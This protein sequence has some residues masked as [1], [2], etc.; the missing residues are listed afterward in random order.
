[1][2]IFETHWNNIWNSTICNV[3]E[4]R[5]LYLFYAENIILDNTQNIANRY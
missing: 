2:A 1:M 5:E 4:F 3:V